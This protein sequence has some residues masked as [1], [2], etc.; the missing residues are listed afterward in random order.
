MQRIDQNIKERLRANGV[1]VVSFVIRTCDF[2][3]RL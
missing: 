1:P 3:P 2:L